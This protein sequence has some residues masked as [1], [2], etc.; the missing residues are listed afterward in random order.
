MT[1]RTGPVEGWRRTCRRAAE[2]GHRARSEHGSGNKS[3]PARV[4]QYTRATFTAFAGVE[5]G[6]VTTSL[7]FES[8]SPAER[9][10]FL[11]VLAHS[12][13]GGLLA[14]RALD[15]RL[16]RRER[17]VRL[18]V[19]MA[20]LS[21]AGVVALLVLRIA[22]QVA[23]SEFGV[24]LMFLIGFGLAGIS[25]TLRTTVHRTY[26]VLGAAAGLAV[27]TLLLGAG[28]G[29][30]GLNAVGVLA[31]GS[32]LVVSYV[33]S[34]WLVDV[35][36][37]LDRAR[38]LHTR[39]A[40]AEERLRFGRDMH[41]VM[42]R[43]LAVI[44]LKSELAVQLAERGRP[45]AVA[46]MSDVQRI[47]RESQ[48]EVREVVRGYR[49]ANLHTELE[50]ARGV[51][52]AAGI[53]CRVEGDDG[54]GLAAEV[55]SA[56]GWVV[57][58]ATT[59]V[60]RH[61]D[62]RRCTVRLAVPGPGERGDGEAVLVVENDGVPAADERDA[63]DARDEGGGKGKAAVPTAGSSD[64]SGPAATPRKGSGLTGLRE[65]LAA[66]DG[67]LEA[68][69]ATGDRFRL[70]ARIPLAVAGTGGAGP[71]ASA[72]G[73]GADAGMSGTEANRTAPMAAARGDSARPGRTGTASRTW[74]GGD[75]DGGGAA[76]PSVAPGAGEEVATA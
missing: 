38:E 30:A 48:R 31:M 35:V 67:T 13:L 6:A 9:W 54:T 49:D 70:T 24:L 18:T 69:R 66:L 29:Q 37:E 56:L 52:A 16:G 4:E 15:W 47:A 60:L 14:N 22:D 51:L 7:L 73:V 76:V 23:T 21:A 1:G 46:Q 33:F 25:L 57:R 74:S 50:G 53:D 55:Q 44:A 62:A 3:K 20:V 19:G 64:G 75:G 17:P 8:A 42:G 11:L 2:A 68:G 72:G 58:E 41:D 5:T 40:V 71:G 32:A 34:A 26:A 65:R 27:V 10:L 61:G 36:W 45:E 63:G 59:N 12:V 43:N 28:W 39:L